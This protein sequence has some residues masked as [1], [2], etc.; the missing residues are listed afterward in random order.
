M[1]WT[2]KELEELYQ[3]INK[4]MAEDPAFREK[5]RKDARAAVE[6]LAGRPLEEGFRLNFIEQ[7]TG[8]GDTYVLPEFVGEELDPRELD[9]IAGGKNVKSV[10]GG[11]CP[12]DSTVGVSVLAIVSACAA[13]VSMSLLIHDKCKEVIGIELDRRAVD[14]ATYSSSY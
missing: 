6:E 5:A 7:D 2:R 12:K 3:K 4:A 10:S 1:S 8:Y 9:A 13:A 14:S 11:D